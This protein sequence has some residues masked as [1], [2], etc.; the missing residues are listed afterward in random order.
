MQALFDGQVS[1]DFNFGNILS[2]F[3]AAVSCVPGLTGTIS[4]EISVTQGGVVTTYDFVSTTA[5]SVN[6]RFAGPGLEAVFDGTQVNINSGQEILFN[7]IVNFVSV[8]VS[9]K[10]WIGSLVLT[11]PDGS[12]IG[13]FGRWH[14]NVIVNHQVYCISIGRTQTM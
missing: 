5:R 4:G 3:N 2:S 14:G 8:K 7:A 6:T 13:V 1:G 12:L 10:E 11:L 9:P